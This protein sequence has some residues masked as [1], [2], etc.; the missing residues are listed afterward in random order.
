[1]SHILSV[2][3]ESLEIAIPSSVCR[4][5]DLVEAEESDVNFGSVDEV[6]ICQN[7]TDRS[8]DAEMREE[9]EENLREGITAVCPTKV[10]TRRWFELVMSQ[11]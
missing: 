6:P 11:T 7:L 8:L 1:M 3:A 4:L 2:P 5:T 9:G 10:S